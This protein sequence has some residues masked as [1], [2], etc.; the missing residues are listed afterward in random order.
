MNV[1]TRSRGL[2]LLSLVVLA[3][4]T[5]VSLWTVWPPAPAPADAPA[6]EFSAQRAFQHVEAVGQEVHPAGSPAAGDVRAHI[7]D[8]L[9]DLGLEPEVV[10]GVGATGALGSTYGL[11]AVQNVV[12][13]IPGTDSTGRIFLVAHYDS[14]QVSYGANDDGAGT[15]TLLETAR[16]LHE[17]PA[18]KNDVVLLFTDA[19]EACLCGAEAFVHDAPLGADGGVVLNV[20]ARGASGPAIMFETSRGNAALV[21]VYSTVP[22]PVGSS[23]AV[24]V[25]RILPNDTDFTPFREQERFTG[26]NSAYIDGSAVYHSPEDRPEYMDLASLQHH[27]S[28]A[29]ALVRHLGDDDIAA[30]SVPSADDATYFPVLGELARYPGW[31]VWPV[32][33]LALLA[34]V[35]LGWLSVRSGLVRGRRL[36]A[37]FAWGLAPIVLVAVV[38]QLFWM[39]LVA[40]RPGYSEMIDPWQP[41]WFRA[42]LMALVATVLLVWFG[43]LRGRLGAPALVVGALGWLAVL[44]LVLAAV[45]P[46]GSYLAALPALAGG[47]GGIVA[48]RLGETGRVVVHTVV[49]A[50]AVVV[51]APIVLLFLPALGLA[52]GAAPALFAVLLGLALLPVLDRVV[53]AGR[54]ALLPALVAG[55]LAVACVG[56]GLVVDRFDERHPLPTQLMYALDAD[57]GKAWWVS[58]EASPSDWTSQYVSGHDDVASTF[59][60]LTDGVWTGSAEAAD[61]PAPEITTN[62]DTTADGVRTLELT[63]VPQ[64]PVRLVGLHLADAT[65]RTAEVEG[66]DVPVSDGTFDV[67]FNAP[68]A[69]GVHVTLTLDPGTAAT[70]RVADGSDGLEDLPGFRPRPPGVGI[71]GS[72]TSELVLVGR[73]VSL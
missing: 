62:S 69:D 34:V 42:A 71:E 19:E 7:V 31:L 56:V 40:L 33:V 47:V 70:L 13:E 18:L 36:A 27:G 38:A 30:L 21:D 55:A 59:P 64:R 39:L 50:V 15:A 22:H 2:S 73:S 29:L 14:V 1:T 44:G 9:T 5:A 26:L 51:L 63:V 45:T 61:L 52:T 72:H 25:Y 16:A 6:D 23:M 17:G 60:L 66:R 12:A 49:G 54:R 43:T 37:G 32:A 48:L 67:V 20:E 24:E 3:V 68:P 35:A 28:N 41:W 10:D 11:A 58:S 57:S 4:L 46:G 53:P 8:T 65:V